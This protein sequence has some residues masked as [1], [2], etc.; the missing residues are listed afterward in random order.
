[1]SLRSAL[2]LVLLA[3]GLGA[4]AYWIERPA[5]EEAG[6]KKTLIELDQDAVNSISLTYQDRE[7]QLQKAD[8]DSWRLE[9]PV[10]AKADDSVV[11]N[12]IRAIAEAEETRKLEGPY[13]DLAPFG[14]DQP[15][16]TIR[17]GLA[18]G[19]AP[20]VLRVG[21]QT[22]IGF[23]AY[24]QKEGDPNVYLTTG[25]FHSG[26]KKEAK[27]VRDKTVIAFKD[28]DVRSIRL[29]KTGSDAIVVERKDDGWAIASPARYDA[30]DGRVRSF[31]STIRNMRAMDFV[32][33]PNDLEALG[34]A[35]ADLEV[36]LETNGDAEGSQATLLIGG[37]VEGDKKQIYVKQAAVDTVFL[38]PE[39][40][41]SSVDQDVNSFR[42]H[43]V[44]PFDP[45]D[46]TE[47]T[48]GKRDGT[49]LALVRDP[50][51]TWTVR[52][53][54]GAPRASAIERFVTDVSQTKP[55]GIVSDDAADFP[56]YG[57]DDPELRIRVTGKEGNS[58]GTLLATRHPE[59]DGD[60]MKFYFARE[61]ASTIFSGGS[62]LMTRLEK[63]R[64][65][66][67]EPD[68][69]SDKEASSAAD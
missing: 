24:A 30:D 11:K 37:D 6:R 60:E 58:I 4:Y 16:V 25:A 5:R 8:D 69:D 39:R 64:E 22:P 52:D 65:D 49:S 43:T 51:R 1:M 67:V 48:L 46:A 68:A 47:V 10:Q 66:F 59:G 45:D 7:I 61:G 62:Y 42:D 20:P 34:L 36:T 9:K 56:R 35:P 50:E 3:A 2:I 29:A 15:M 27:D 17:L 33:D 41:R 53:A 40:I 14:L 55:T 54:T 31:L 18:D 26:V 19:D 44:L 28:E 38:V 12:L 63:K 21:K 23:K 13:D 57:L 32:D